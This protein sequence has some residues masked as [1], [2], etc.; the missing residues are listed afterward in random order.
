[1]IA[2]GDD[3]ERLVEAL[4]GG[5]HERMSGVAVVDDGER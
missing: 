5:G 3:V 2:R 4:G 1:V